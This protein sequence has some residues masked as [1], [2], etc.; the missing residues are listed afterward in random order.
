M[1]NENKEQ[2]FKD[3]KQEIENA[4]IDAGKT[5]MELNEKI[6]IL[7]KII[8]P[9]VK[10]ATEEEKKEILAMAADIDKR[11]AFILRSLLVNHGNVLW[12]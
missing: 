2:L 10:D 6:V 8:L 11:V 9:S 3:K 5:A 1:S 12:V 7:R 4:F